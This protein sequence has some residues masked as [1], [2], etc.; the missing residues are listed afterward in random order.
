MSAEKPGPHASGFGVWALRFVNVL[1][2][3]VQGSGLN[4][5]LPSPKP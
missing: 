2:F 4:P 1:M 3:Q 5:R